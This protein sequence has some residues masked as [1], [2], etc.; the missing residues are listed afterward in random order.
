MDAQ[1]L[2]STPTNMI[3]GMTQKNIFDLV[4][5]R[6][7]DSMCKVQGDGWYSKLVRATMIQ[8]QLCVE[9]MLHA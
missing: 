2:N 5:K 7:C 1:G 4:Q 6:I 8:L 9:I 3:V